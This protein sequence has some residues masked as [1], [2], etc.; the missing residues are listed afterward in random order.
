MKLMRT[1]GKA[2]VESILVSPLLFLNYKSHLFALEYHTAAPPYCNPVRNREHLHARLKSGFLNDITSPE[3]ALNLYKQ[4]VLLDPPPNVIAFTQLLDRLVKLKHYSLAISLYR[5]MT[6]LGFPVSDYILNTV[7]HCYCLVNKVDFGFSV[8][9]GFF[10]RGI[11]PDVCTFGTLLKGL[12]KEIRINQAQELFRKIIFE[13]LCEP[14]IPMCVTVIDGLCKVGN[15]SMAIL[16]L[17]DMERGRVAPDVKVYTAI[18]DSLCKDNR[19]EEAILLLREMIEKGIAPNVVTYTCLIKGFSNIGAVCKEGKLEAAEG[20]L[21]MMTQHG[22]IPNVITY[23]VL[24]EGCCLQGQ[25][26]KLQK[27]FDAMV[28]CGIVPDLISYGILIKGY[29]KSFKADDAIHIFREMPQKGVMPSAATYNAVL[30]G[31]FRMGRY[32]TARHVFM[33]MQSVSIPPDFLTYSI[34]LDG[35]CKSGSVDQAIEFLHKFKLETEGVELHTTMYNIIL[36]GLCKCGRLDTA[37]DVFRSISLKGLDPD[38]TTY[39]TMIAGLCREGLV[40]EAKDY[41]V[42]MEENGVLADERTY[43]TIIRGL[44]KIDEFDDAAIYVEELLRREFSLD[45]S[46][47]SL[48]LDLSSNKANCT[49]L[50]KVIQNLGSERMKLMLESTLNGVLQ[51]FCLGLVKSESIYFILDSDLANPNLFVLQTNLVQKCEEQGGIC[52]WQSGST[53]RIGCLGGK[54]HQSGTL[55]KLEISELKKEPYPHSEGGEMSVYDHVD[56]SALLL[57]HLRI[58]NEGVKEGDLHKVTTDTKLQELCSDALAGDRLLI[59][60]DYP[61]NDVVD[62]TTGEDAESESDSD[63]SDRDWDEKD[64]EYDQE[65]SENDY[66]LVA[67]DSGG[68]E[69]PKNHKA[70]T[71][72]AGAKKLYNSSVGAKKVQPTSLT[73]AYKYDEGNYNDNSGSELEPDSEEDLQS[74]QGSDGED[75]DKP[76]LFHPEDME[77]PPLRAG[78]TFSSRAECKEAIRRYNIRRGRRWRFKKDDKRRIKAICPEKYK[79]NHKSKTLKQCDWIIYVSMCSGSPVVTTFVTWHKCKFR[80]R[81]KSVTSAITGRICSQLVKDNQTITTRDYKRL[82]KE[83]Y[84]FILTKTQAY[85]ARRKSMRIVYGNVEDQ[86]DKLRDYCGEIMKSNHGSTVARVA[87][88]MF[89][90]EITRESVLQGQ[91][92]K[93]HKMNQLRCLPQVSMDPNVAIVDSQVTTRGSALSLTHQGVVDLGSNVDDFFDAVN[94]GANNDVSSPGKRKLGDPNESNYEEAS[95]HESHIAEMRSNEALPMKKIQHIKKKQKMSGYM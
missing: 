18:V 1:K 43:N 48:L 27:I 11:V 80:Q 7:I 95:L 65:E 45:S 55:K 89:V 39:N 5:N 57:A 81:N 17:R 49:A 77:K 75:V 10:K 68:V 84:K 13:K 6:A 4:M 23:N 44:L 40:K 74:V 67:D 71:S 30:Q 34:M 32:A 29:F 22:Q 38:V 86:Y 24:M 9:G 20:F 93:G 85:R 46:T 53:N 59:L 78:L 82:A 69:G 87:D 28:G 16:F 79:K 15:T 70:S 91:P 52:G 12:F 41:I 21:Q 33:E 66:D 72:S 92:H 3:D 36:D 31:L 35:L 14:D 83:K 47:F 90:D 8:L 61:V 63:S 37:R 73:K 54:K 26:S 51:L 76:M 2:F 42:K 94:L 25:I 56:C 88:P 50:A 60:Y 58:I 19:V 64:S 62:D